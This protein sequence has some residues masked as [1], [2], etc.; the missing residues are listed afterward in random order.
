MKATLDPL[1][2]DR[3]IVEVNER[4][5]IALTEEDSPLTRMARHDPALECSWDGEVGDGTVPTLVLTRE[6]ATVA[7]GLRTASAADFD[8]SESLKRI[9]KGGSANG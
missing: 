3:I 2:A 8:L 1:N 5:F 7:V 4:E 6:Q 9:L